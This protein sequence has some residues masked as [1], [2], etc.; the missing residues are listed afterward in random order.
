MEASLGLTRNMIIYHD[1]NQCHH[2]FVEPVITIGNFDGIHLG[3]Q[4]IFRRVMERADTRHGQSV[5]LTFDPHP[6]KVMRPEADLPLLT[7]TAQKIRLLSALGLD[8][9]V[10]QPF[11]REFAALPAREF[12]IEYLCRRLDVKELVVGHDYRFGC[13][14]EGD[15]ALLQEIGV[16]H[17]FTVEVVD[18]IQINH[19]VVSSTLVRNLVRAGNMAEANRLL[20]RAYEVTGVVIPGHGRGARLLKIPTANLRLDNELLPAPGIY[21]VWATVE[22]RTYPAVANIG[23]CPTFQESELSLEVHILDFHQ[24]IYHRPLAVEFVQRLRDERRFPSIPELAAQIQTDI[25]RA[26]QLLKRV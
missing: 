14:R 2:P 22:G 26:R 19:T 12:V 11:T 24:D 1:L 10:I 18:A 6:L 7:T 5:V 16:Q 25:T 13:R 9:M 21:A 20:G 23:T 8:A 3:H 15:I 17:G 4:I